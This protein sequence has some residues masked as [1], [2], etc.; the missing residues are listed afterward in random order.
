M[1]KSIAFLMIMALGVTLVSGCSTKKDER[2]MTDASNGLYQTQMPAK[3]S[4]E[5]MDGATRKYDV[6]TDSIDQSIQVNGT[7]DGMN[8]EAMKPEESIQQEIIYDC[9]LN[10]IHMNTEEYNAIEEAG[11]LS[12]ATQPLSTFSADVDTASYSNVRRMINQGY[13]DPGAV[14]IEEM[15]NYFSYDYKTPDGEH[16][17]GVTTEVA[18]CPWNPS[19]KLMLV[20]I[21]TEKVDFSKAPSSNLVFLIDVSGSMMDSDKLPLVQKAFAMLTENLTEKD[22]I[23]IVTYASNEEVVLRGVN[24]TKREEIMDAVN[25]LSAGGSTAGSAGITTAY[26]IAEEFFIEGGNNRVILATD[27]DLNVGVSSESELTRLIETKK[28]SG[29]YLSVLG[30]GT[31]NIKDNKME[32]LADHGNGNYSYIDSLLEAKKVLVEEMGATLYTVAEDVKFQVEFN[33]AKVK[34]YRL[35]GY[36]NRLMAAEDFNDDTKDAG[37]VGAGHSVTALYEIALSDSNLDIP[38]TDLKY[39][40]STINADSDELLTISIRYKNPGEK[41]SI[42]MEVPVK[43]TQIQPVMSEN[44]MFAAA[45]TEFGMI[46]RDSTY[47]GTS[48]Y[49]TILHLLSDCHLSDDIYKTEFVT[50]VKTAKDM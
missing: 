4:E 48:S 29:V 40:E 24:G 44:L 21:Q 18:D 41:K 43:E 2:M 3:A 13:V 9:E 28:K 35:I 20:G 47:Q 11:F 19:T 45:V 26:E 27:G 46:L 25:Q 49:D 31:G 6:L 33:P 1:K 42:L 38:S 50:L 15:L 12:A 32:A 23:S 34:A 37:E 8:Q 10:P 17:F 5:A 22:R 30:F 7:M 14:R 36:D 16:P 39:Q